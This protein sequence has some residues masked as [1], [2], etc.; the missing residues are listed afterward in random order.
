[1]RIFVAGATGALGRRLVPA[2]AAAGHQVSGSTRRPDRAERLRAAGAEPVVLDPL[3]REAVATA[4]AAA[5]PEVVMHQLSAL[6]TA[7][8]S[9]RRFDR[10]F[11]STNRLRTDGL[12]HLLAAAVAAG[13]R[14]F[15]AQSFTG[16]P[17]Q[18]TGGP[19]KTEQDPLDPH[20]AAGSR[21]TLAALRYLESAVVS[22]DRIEG[23]ALR[24]GLFY[25]PGT[26]LALDGAICQL[27][28]K[29]RLPVVGGGSGVWSFIHLDDA[30]SATVAAVE[31]GAPG[32]Y[33]IVDDEPARIAEWLPYLA[34]AIGAKPPQ[35]VPA[36]LVRPVLGAHGVSMMTAIRG[37]S[38]AKARRE[39]GWELRYPS[40]RQGF[41][42][43][44]GAR[45]RT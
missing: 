13:A 24:Y 11:A 33:N 22:A 39:L 16:W 35:R 23:L 8:G 19:V 42:T 34:E 44:L 12:D 36:W 25:G 9:A 40:W 37:S 20:P 27:V 38:N 32:L 28:R 14:R 3:D 31:L 17:N 15:I 30:A 43:G 18:R 29:R 4:V 7:A 21:Q 5:R 45:S 26:G 41:R 6:S 1:M 2:L 10:E